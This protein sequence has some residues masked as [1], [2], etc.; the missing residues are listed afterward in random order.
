MTKRAL[1]NNKG[2]VLLQVLAVTAAMSISFYMLSDYVIA[3]KKE[4]GKTVNAV[5]LRFALNST[6]D[7]VL[8]GLRQKYCFTDDDLLMNSPTAQCNLSHTGSVERLIMSGDQE[9]FILQLLATGTDVGPLDKNNIPLKSIT[10]YL[11]VSA[12]TT[13]HPLFPVLQNLKTVKDEITGKV[14]KVDGVSILLEKDESG[15]LPRAGREVYLRA[16]ISLKSSKT[17][18]TPISIGSSPLKITSQI[19]IY[20]REVGSFALMVPKDLH[21]DTAWNSTQGT[22]D[23]S[24]HRFASKSEIG[25][26]QGLVFLSPVFVNQDIYLPQDKRP[27][28]DNSAY[29]GLYAPVTFAD[30]VYMGNGWVKNPDGSQFVPRSSGGLS[31]RFW[32]DVPTFGGFLRGIENDGGLDRGLQVFGRIIAGSSADTNLMSQCIERSQNLSSSDYLYK[33]ELAATLKDDSKNDLRYRLFLSNKNEFSP[34]DNPMLPVQTS[35]F[36]K[37]KV[38]R[39]GSGDPIFKMTF[40]LGNKLVTAQ[41]S[42]NT[43][44]TINPEVG[45]AA[46]RAKLE[47]A[48]TSAQSSLTF[49]KT[50]LSDFNNQ[51][52]K[53]QADL[54]AA[55]T[56]LANELKKPEEPEPTPTPAPTATPTP[57]PHLNITPTPSPSP[58]PSASPDSGDS[59]EPSPSP[60]VSP[61]ASPSPTATPKATPTPTPTP[62]VD[63]QDQ[64]LITNLKGRIT[65]LKNT[66]NQLQYTDVPKQQDVVKSAD[67]A[68]AK[69]KSDLATLAEPAEIVIKVSKVYSRFGVY[70]DRYDVSITASRVDHLLDDNGNP[71]A[72]SIGFLAYD[73]TYYQ[74]APIKTPSNGKLLRYLNFGI[75][76]DRKSLV[77]PGSMS[78]TSASA[79]AGGIAEDDTDYAHLDVLCE[80]ARN[81]AASQSFGGASWNVDFSGT[82]RSSWNFAGDSSS[83][84]GHDPVFNKTL[85]LDSGADGVFKVYSIAKECVISASANVIT[86]FYTCDSL[87]IE[88]RQK[89]LRII[90]TF[91]VGKLQIDPSAY[92]AGIVWSS[93]YHPQVTQELRS[94][95]V[96]KSL[97][98]ASCDAPKNPIWHPKPSVQ[99]VSDRMACNVISLRAKADPFQWTAVDPDCGLLPNSSNTTC[100]RRLVRFF[101]VEQAREGGR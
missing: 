93:I 61:S 38:D 14:L 10:R 72:P 23:V 88:A 53:A 29:N 43:E 22:G 13:A 16:T 19:V 51:L 11:K 18:T 49:A 1:H 15:Y 95:G 60:S 32:S 30:R 34:Q 71:I 44:I 24:F 39:D 100:K 77:A 5:N 78:E 96:L 68:L 80:Q 3:Q 85:V 26:G 31:D 27:A 8:Y 92:K 4:I 33:S 90:G 66:V 36:G 42:R 28:K 21:L 56:E 82:T 101:V 62:V 12:A 97:S 70:E 98:G 57:T 64:D 50:Q 40:A 69:A 7:Y 63:Y 76:S 84:I 99:E 6:M 46:Y 79:S 17:A 81:A 35:N 48:V 73:G 55:Q 47:S 54:S 67:A 9:N 52:S 59:T 83:Q 89:P 20:P 91:I 2:N 87:R 58:S 65:A 41:L 45:G 25:S 75:S 94:I 74:S 86:G 37:G